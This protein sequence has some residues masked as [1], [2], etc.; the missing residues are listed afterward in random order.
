MKILMTE[1]EQSVLHLIEYAL[2]GSKADE[3]AKIQSGL[4][5]LKRSHYYPQES[6]KNRFFHWMI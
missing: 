2:I 3:P 1:L 5:R 4:G 6:L